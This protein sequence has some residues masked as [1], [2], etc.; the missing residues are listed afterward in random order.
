MSLGK[1]AGIF[2][3]AAFTLA[4]T[5]CG[6]GGSSSS[7]ATN[8]ISSAVQD[9]TVDPTG[10]TTVLTFASTSGLAGAT[11]ANFETDGAQTATSVLVSGASATVVWDARVSPQS[12]VR[13]TGLSGVSAAFSAVTTSN[14]AAPTF[15]ITN[16]TQGAGLG[17]DSFDVVFSGPN[18]IE[19]EVENLAHWT[20]QTN[21]TTQSLTGSVITFNPG[22]QTATFDLGT[23]MGLHA[24]YTLQANGIHSV[25]DVALASTAVAGTATGDAV[26]PT[27]TSSIQNL[28]QSEY[29]TVIDFTFSK[30]MDPTFSVQTSHY[31]VTSPDIATT[32]TQPSA[33][34]LRVTF[35]NPIVPGVDVVSLSSLV[36]A[37]GNAFP[38]GDQ[39][40]TQPSPVVNAFDGA[41]TATTV[42][43]AGGDTITVVTTQ[44]F[45]PDTAVDPT[46]WT[47]S[48]GGSPVDLTLQTLSYDLLTK[49]LTIDLASDIQNGQA[50]TITGVSVKDV[51]GQTFSLSSGGTV[52]GD[53]VAPTITSVTQNR[54]TDST[55]K[56]LVVQF[57][58]DLDETTAE[59]LVNWTISGTQNLTS[60]TLLGGGDSV[61]LVF[62]AVVVPGDVT[63]SAANV[64]DLAGN[65]MVSVASLPIV[66]TD[67]TRP[68]P[69]SATASAIA[70]ANND[71]VYVQFD[72]DMIESEIETPANWTVESPIGSP[73]ST[74]GTTVI[75]DS[76]TH[77]AA[78]IL[79]NGINFFRGDDFNVTFTNC[80]DIS[81]NLVN[82]TVLSGNITSESTL[83]TVHTVY[84][85]STNTD[86]LVIVF[87]EPCGELT[88]LYNAGSNPTGTRFVLR[89]SGGVLRGLPTNATV[90]QEGLAVRVAY[91]IVIAPTDTVDVLGVT[92]L[93]GNP[94]FPAL[95]VATIAEN[96][97]FPSLDTGFSAF[98][99][100]TGEGNDQVTVVF[101]RPMSP[102]N[103]LNPANYTLTGT[104]PIDVTNAVFSFNGTNTVTIGLRNFANHNLQTGGSYT[105]SVNNVWSAQGTPRAVSDTEVGIVAVGDSTSPTVAV[106]KVRLDPSDANSLLIE[107][108]EALDVTASETASNYDCNGG[109]IAVSATRIGPRVVR[110]TFGSAPVLGQSLQFTAKDL[111]GNVSGSI[112]RT[113]AAAD[114]T[115]PLV[116]SVAGIIRPGYGGDSITVTFNE[117]VLGSTAL[118]AANY[119]ISTGAT[120]LSM[121][122]A[123][124][125]YTSAQNKVTIVLA[126]GQELDSTANVFVTIANVTDV[127]GNAMASQIT[128]GGTVTGDTTAPS[129]SKAFV[130]LRE[131][132]TGGIV[133]VLFSED[134]DTTYASTTSNWT[135]SG[136]QT[137]SGVTM[138]EKNHARLT[139]SAPLGASQ[140]LSIGNVPDLARNTSAML[141]VDPTE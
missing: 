36:D 34:V 24:T 91:G 30:A 8:T 53:A 14:A 7:S 100:V 102:W 67:S 75:Y 101:D 138:L 73:I 84:R 108:D 38:D 88:D 140:T 58:E 40:I 103:L 11:T 77:A 130:N 127:A 114:T 42:A 23:A 66:T 10:S 133:D 125:A 35:N 54:N 113:I 85:D 52:A 116:S 136:G 110:A 90:L 51:D 135:A 134:V 17:N 128:V 68:T 5:G 62:D 80:R 78:L 119:Q 86:E 29:G 70:G 25:A 45:D 118:N 21:S 137:V 105:L 4:F 47:L 12:Q 50:F 87:S 76:G 98:T 81:A 124:I 109:N 123:R 13:A 95:A 27:I 48:V 111:A 117:Q 2:A 97:T 1:L 63:L 28:A 106:G 79:Q 19:S 89:D 6:G 92:D 43:N 39:A 112:S 9:L 41:P 59:T 72:D 141:T 60:A 83:P 65:T 139:L 31:G 57:S 32:V 20:I 104:G 82:T 37:H 120:P 131:D 94:M 15:T 56:T 3:F 71:V 69:T 74:V 18:V 96:T 107:S 115:G 129:I 61:S 126:D 122:N 121:V 16:G 64:K 93:C 44:A 49:T 26:A 132:F 46:A 22:T 55:G 99:S 33:N